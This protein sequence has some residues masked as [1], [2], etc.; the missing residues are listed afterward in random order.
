MVALPLLTVVTAEV[1]PPPLRVTDPEGVWLELP[2]VTLMV[3]AIYCAVV[4]LVA[5]GVSVTAG[6]ALLTTSVT[7]AAPVV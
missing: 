4:M 3:T 6:A 5:D 1:Y 7:V 2:A